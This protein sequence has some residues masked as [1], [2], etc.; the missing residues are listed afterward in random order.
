M[1]YTHSVPIEA[2]SITGSALLKTCNRANGVGKVYA[3]EITASA[4][5]TA[6]LTLWD[7]N[8]AAGE[9]EW[10]ISATAG[11]SNGR[12][13]PDSKPLR[14]NRYIY[15]QLTGAGAIASIQFD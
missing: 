6:I 9:R 10:V 14:F 15:A 11:D 4:Q 7:N 3:I 12:T 2:N 8:A 1:P 13:F 5:A